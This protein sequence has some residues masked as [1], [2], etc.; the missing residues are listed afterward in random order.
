MPYE[1]CNSPLTSLTNTITI[2]T[3]SSF[4]DGFIK[5]NA[6]PK[7]ILLMKK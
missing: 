4:S 2:E 3:E 1:Y 6:N 5:F 7:Q